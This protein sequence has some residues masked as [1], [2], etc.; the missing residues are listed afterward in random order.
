MKISEILLKYKTDKNYGKISP[1]EGHY[2]GDSYDSIFEKFN[3][4]DNLNILE[5]GIQ[6]GGSL[7]AWKEFFIN[8]KITGVDIVDVISDEYR[9]E[10][11]NY[12]FSD[13]K[14][15]NTKLQL[16]NEMFD[17]II[18]DGSHQ[19]EDVIFVVDTYLTNL[20][21][22]GVLIIEDCQSPEMWVSRIQP[23]LNEE[24]SL[25]THDL[26]KINNHYDDFIIEIKKIK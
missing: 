25:I 2:Y 1:K 17:I 3:K 24:F 11:F 21:K 18:D 5:I 10:S 4:N 16:K 14:S 22:N 9:N 8:S 6:K 15:E 19:L 13:I 23:L 20:N 12:I 26:R 7:L